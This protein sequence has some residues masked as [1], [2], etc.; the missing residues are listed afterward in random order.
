MRKKKND[1]NV[2]LLLLVLGEG[3]E[4]EINAEVK[5]VVERGF[6]TK[7]H[8]TGRT[9]YHIVSTNS[10]VVKLG[11]SPANFRNLVKRSLQHP[12]DNALDCRVLRS[13]TADNVNWMLSKIKGKR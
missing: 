13:L 10:G 2:H 5:P 6:T 9:T 7:M 3:T 12:K 11:L 1:N 8:Y 4:I